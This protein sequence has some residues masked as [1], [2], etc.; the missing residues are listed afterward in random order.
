QQQAAQERLISET[1]ARIREQLDMDAVLQ[2]AVHELQQVLG[3]ERVELRVGTPPAL[4]EVQQVTAG[5]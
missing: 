2:A 1:T 3:L 5:D 4:E